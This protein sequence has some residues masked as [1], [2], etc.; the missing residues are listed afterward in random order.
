MIGGHDEQVVRPQPAQQ[1]GQAPVEA[2]E[3]IGVARHVAA[4]AELGIEVDV[5]GKQQAALG[6]AGCGL[7]RAVEQRVITVALHHLARAAMGEDVRR[8]ADGDDRPALRAGT[9]EQGRRWRRYRIIAPVRGAPEA[10]LV[11]AD[12]RP[13]DDAADAQRVEQAAGDHARLGEPVEAERLLVGGDLEHTVG[14]GVADRFQRR[15][16]LGAKLLDDG[17]TGRMAVPEDARQAGAGA[18][19]R[20]DLG[21]K[22]GTVSGK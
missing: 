22:Q 3:R 12:E 7:E 21:G 9:L 15:E 16:M 6:Q 19:V 2:L 11:L 14:R 4:M 20:D 13:R 17:G 5:V 1:L 18:Q 10:R 8:L